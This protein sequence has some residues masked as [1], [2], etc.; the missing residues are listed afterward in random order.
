MNFDNI[1]IAHSAWK[2]RIKSAIN[3]GEKLDA[4][5][6]SKDNAC[7]LGK[8][9]YGEGARYNNLPEFQTLKQKHAQFHQAAGETIRKAAVLPKSE[10]L[11]LLDFG[12]QY[13][14]ISSQCTNAISVLKSKVEK[15]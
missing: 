2:I 4:A 12:S 10:A 7:D 14:Q 11:K 8:W 9:I 6:V 1:I 15:G 13:S 5:V 3:T